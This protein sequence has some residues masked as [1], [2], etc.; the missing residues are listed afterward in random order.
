[1]RRLLLLVAGLVVLAAAAHAQPT[2]PAGGEFSAPDEIE[3]HLI[4][5]LRTSNKAQTNRYVP[6]VYTFN[7]V[8]PYDVLRFIRRPMEI[9]EGA[10][11]VFGKPENPADPTS[12]KGGKVVVI[13]PVYQI[14]YLDELMKTIDTPGLTTSSGDEAYYYRPVHRHVEDSDWVDVLKGLGQVGDYVPDSEVNAFLFYDSPSVIED[15]KRW[16]PVIDQPPAQAMV[17]A[18]VYE[19]NVENDNALG[20]DYV[21]WKNGPG[22]DLFKVGLFSETEKISELDGG[23]PMFDSGVPGGTY[24]LPGHT[25]STHGAYS[26]YIFDLPSAFF[27]FLVSKQKARVLTSSKV[28]ARNATTASLE[29]VDSIFYWRTAGDR[30]VEEATKD[31]ETESTFLDVEPA[32]VFLNITP[33]IGTEGI[34]LEVQLKIVSNTGFAADGHPQLVGRVYGTDADPIVLR[35]KDGGEVILGGYTREIAVQQ[36]SKVPVLGSLPVVGWLFGGEQNLIKRR[37]VFVVLRAHTVK[38]YSAIADAGSEIDAALIRARAKREQPTPT[39][40]TPAGFDQWLLDKEGTEE[41]VGSE[42]REGDKQ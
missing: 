16:L 10:W 17:E 11:F 18:T 19:V 4:K 15:L 12:V 8:N 42:N 29:A 25:F 1:M 31:R 30:R 28:L 24:S 13:A 5:I 23:A 2:P 37:H 36:T 3:S 14:P 40:T 33:L 21:A 35:V 26:S 41:R 22:R 39:L 6:K 34:N 32:G 38:D 20:L 9:E 7:N 27:D